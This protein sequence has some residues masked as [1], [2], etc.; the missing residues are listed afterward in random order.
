MDKKIEEMYQ[1]NA[2]LVYK[3]VLCLCHDSFLAE[4]LVQETFYQAMRSINRYDGTCKLSVW[5]C[6]IAKHLWYREA[7]RR[8][9]FTNMEFIEEQDTFFSEKDVEETI[10]TKESKIELYRKIQDLPSSTRDVMYLRLNRGLEL[11]RNWR[12]TK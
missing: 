11:C 10:C 4:E 12:N 8:S 6:Q 1:E 2:E 3:Y 9:R 7:K 5:L